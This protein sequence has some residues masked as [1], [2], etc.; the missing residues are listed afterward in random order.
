MLNF[1]LMATAKYFSSR[2]ELWNNKYNDMKT[3]QL[4]KEHI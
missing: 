1:E 4:T 3:G 2:V